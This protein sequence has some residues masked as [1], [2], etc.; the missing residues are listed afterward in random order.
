MATKN[1]I[2]L[3]CNNCGKLALFLVSV[4]RIDPT[5]KLVHLLWC[6]ECFLHGVE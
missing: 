1:G 4:D 6:R 2:H 3:E 5:G